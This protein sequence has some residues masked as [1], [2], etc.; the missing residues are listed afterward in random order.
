MA[1][2]SPLYQQR[3]TKGLAAELDVR[4]L[5]SGWEQEFILA[6]AGEA[7]RN[8]E[9]AQATTRFVPI[10]RNLQ[11]ALNLLLGVPGMGQWTPFLTFSGLTKFWG[12]DGV[13]KEWGSGLSGAGAVRDS[14]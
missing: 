10:G 11:R 3:V 12:S 1:Y 6:L 7:E 8:S 13:T 9:L 4:D 14:L 2:Y 5:D